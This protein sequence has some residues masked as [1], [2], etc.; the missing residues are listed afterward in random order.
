[1]SK[2]LLVKEARRRAEVFRNLDSYLKTIAETV[3]EIDGEAEIYLFGSVAEGRH[4]L[5]SDIDVL[6]VTNT[7]PGVVLA[8]LWRKGIKDPF[9]IHVVTRNMFKIYE[10]RTKLVKIA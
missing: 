9:E 3:R 10:R 6:I 4:M 2:E 1:L 8:E 5:S 7:P